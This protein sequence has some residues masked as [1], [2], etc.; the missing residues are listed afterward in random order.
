MIQAGIVARDEGMIMPVILNEGRFHVIRKQRNGIYRDARKSADHN[1][2]DTGPDEKKVALV[3][4]LM[5][6]LFGSGNETA[7]TM[8]SRQM[9]LRFPVRE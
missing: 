5:V 1:G 9:E 4:P 8:L 6:A 2:N 3:A 7:S